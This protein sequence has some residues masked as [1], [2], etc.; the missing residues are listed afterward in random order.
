MKDCYLSPLRGF[1]L[2]GDRLPTAHAVGYD[3]TPLRGYPANCEITS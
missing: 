3:L 1:A 2:L